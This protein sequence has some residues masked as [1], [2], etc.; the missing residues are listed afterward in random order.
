MKNRSTRTYVLCSLFSIVIVV[1]VIPPEAKSVIEEI[2][3]KFICDPFL[4]IRYSLT[5]TSKSFNIKDN[6]F[7][8]AV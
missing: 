7:K 2:M 4:A 3:L 8:S 1:V 6:C 5:S